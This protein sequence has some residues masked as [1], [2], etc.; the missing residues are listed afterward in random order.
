VANFALGRS[1]E[2]RIRRL[3]EESALPLQ[4]EEQEATRGVRQ[5]PTAQQDV[6]ALWMSALLP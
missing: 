6:G 5:F 2:L 4:A 1:G 3:R